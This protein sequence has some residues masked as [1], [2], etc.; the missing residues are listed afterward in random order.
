MGNYYFLL[1]KS[2]FLLR[3]SFLITLIFL[4]NLFFAGNIFADIE[5]SGSSS[6]EDSD[7]DWNGDGILDG[8]DK[9][10][11]KTDRLRFRTSGM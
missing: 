9:N 6:Y 8:V 2:K 7:Q 5:H 4:V 11:Q 10:G 1:I 3:A